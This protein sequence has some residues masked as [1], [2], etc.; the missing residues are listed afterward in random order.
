MTYDEQLKD[1]RWL[2]KAE[3]IKKRDNYSCQLCMK[4]KD[5]QAHHKTYLPGLMAWEYD[6][7]YLITLCD[8]CHNKQHG[9]KEDANRD[10]LDRGDPHESDFY[11]DRW[12]FIGDS[13][14]SLIGLQIQQER[15]AEEKRLEELQKKAKDDLENKDN[16]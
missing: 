1:P 4:G 12:K 8:G 9:K 13:V 11:E 16:G 14:R 15:K 5:L 7:H 2:I 6:D 10:A 3:K